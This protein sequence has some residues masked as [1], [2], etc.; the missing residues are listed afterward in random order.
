[1]DDALL[2]EWTT[3]AISKIT[4]KVNQD[5][6]N[7]TM[8][9]LAN[10]R[11]V[12]NADGGLSMTNT[13]TQ[14]MSG[15]GTAGSPLIVSPL[16]PS[17]LP[18]ADVWRAATSGDAVS[19]GGATISDLNVV[20]MDDDGYAMHISLTTTDSHDNS[21]EPPT[22]NAM[23][24]EAAFTLPQVAVATTSAQAPSQPTTVPAP[25]EIM[26]PQDDSNIPQGFVLAG[27]VK[28]F[29]LFDE[30]MYAYYG[31]AATGMRQ[32]VV[33]DPGTIKISDYIPSL[34]D[35]AFEAVQLQNLQFVYNECTTAT[36]MAG[37]WVQADVLFSGPLQFISDF[38]KN[39]C[40]QE[41]P[42]L[43][44][45]ALL[46][47]NN[48]WSRPMSPGQLCLRGS[49]PSMSIKLGDI[50]TI[51]DMGIGLSLAQTRQPSPP[52]DKEWN[53]GVSF[54]GS[55]D[56]EAPNDMAP[57]RASFS[58]TAIAGVLNLVLDIEENETAGLGFS[59][60]EG[61]KLSDLSMSTTLAMS[62]SPALVSFDASATLGFEDT[63]LRLNG[64]Y[65]KSY[66]AFQCEVDNF[67][68]SDIR[69]MYQSLF[70]GELYLSEHEIELETLVFS[71]D[72]IGMTFTG[73]VT[74]EGHITVQATISLSR[75]GIYITGEVDNVVLSGDVILKKAAL[76]VFVGRSDHTSLSGPGT[77]FRFVIVGIVDI[78]N[79]EISVS[80]YL[81]KDAGRQMFWTAI[82]AF[83]GAFSLSRIEPGLKQTFLDLAVEDVVFI[84]SNVDGARATGATIPTAYPIINTVQIAA[85]LGPVATIDGALGRKG[86]PTSGLTLDAMYSANKG[87]FEL[88]INL[89]APQT[90]SMKGGSVYCGPI[91]LL[92]MTTPMPTMVIK[93]E[94][95]VKVPNQ[96]NP[97]KFDGGMTL[98]VDEAKLFIEMKDSWWNSPFGLSRQLRL[99]PDLALQIGVVYAGP[100]YPSELG[101]EGGLAVGG[102]TGKAALSISE[103]PNDELI[104][105][106]VNNLG[107]K[108]IVDLASQLFELRL[109]EPEDFLRFKM[110]KLYLSTGTTIGTTYYPPGASFSCDALIFE[111]YRA[112][113]YCGVDKSKKQMQIKGSL[114]QVDIG[115][116]SIG[117]YSPG[118]PAQL[119]VQMG[120]TQTLF[121]DGM[122]RFLGST[123]KIHVAA[124]LQP[125]TMF[126]LQTE[127]DFSTHLS[128]MLEASERKGQMKPDSVRQV[129]FDVH[130]SFHQDILDYIVAQINTQILAAKHKADKGIEASEA[131]LHKAQQQYQASIDVA[132]T[133]VDSAKK[134]YDLK[135]NQINGALA[136]EQNSCE[137][138]TQKLQKDIERSNRCSEVEVAESFRK[139]GTGDSESTASSSRCEA[140]G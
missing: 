88:A 6:V 47:P 7:G 104:M 125:S 128:F 83:D 69:K 49:L 116:L 67:D 93:A 87:A 127:L 130:A 91:S 43:R 38:F 92:I 120:R 129:E 59:G 1:M 16:P 138:R 101:L 4:G 124:E 68:F 70:G 105:L 95:F 22:V 20:A 81:D 106:E 64:F 51:T 89:S 30:Q 14:L 32:I 111:R 31:N 11:D 84:A 28:L 102:A 8:P 82:G 63:A 46:S 74:V 25:T 10:S 117:G 78:C 136:A 65:S 137:I 66:W 98:N 121:I 131:V 113:I 26:D 57:M 97:L 114:D 79:C 77:S 62:S 45:E 33:L 54:F 80:L 86:T 44:M 18:H 135:V 140:K 50:V 48:D 17:E 108:D 15:A 122:A 99:G 34:A 21:G 19:A 9:Q 12:A 2:K 55:I 27:K 103:A 110:A 73:V 29:G 3:T 41:K 53:M 109:P 52:F 126:V 134:A 115:P 132:Q 42:A 123:V 118:H 35:S 76:N 24:A 58:I 60:V 72:S 90:M 94:F 112:Q 39:V 23:V 85:A 61:S 75:L 139:S 100:L 71:A 56:L 36:D 40:Q 107:V 37:T 13:A 5:A 133:Q 96:S 119:D